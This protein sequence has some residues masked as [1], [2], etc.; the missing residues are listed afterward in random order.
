MWIDIT[1]LVLNMQ[2]EFLINEIDCHD[3]IATWRNKAMQIIHE[4]QKIDR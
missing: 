4:S 2:R 1:K 3:G